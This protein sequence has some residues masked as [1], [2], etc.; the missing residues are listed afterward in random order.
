MGLDL[1]K[2]AA[3]I[4][5]LAAGLQAQGAGHRER[6][7]RAV[8]TLASADAGAINQRRSQGRVTWLVPGLPPDIAAHISPTPPPADYRALAVDGSHIDVDRHLPVRCA[9]VNISKVALQYGASP[10][11]R[12]ESQP[13]LYA[14][15]EE[16]ALVDPE[17]ARELPLEG[18][19]LGIKRSVDEVAALA[20]LAEEATD[21]TPT[22]ALVDG[23]LI[24]WGLTGQAYPEYVRRALIEDGL[25][26]AME[27]LR[28]I[29]QKRPLALAAYV[30]LPRSTEVVNALRVSVCPYEPVDC[31]RN[32]A[33]VRPGERPCDVVG[34]LLDRELFALLLAPGERSAA[35]ASTSSVVRD[36]YGGHAV[37][38]YYVNVGTEMARVEVP[39]WVADDEALLALTHSLLL[40]QCR[41][42]LGYPVAI[43]EAHEQAVIGG[44]EREMFRQM[45]EDALER[46]HLP[47]YTSE[48]ARSKRLRWV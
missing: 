17:G 22:V 11:A 30:S 3:Q 1:H 47:V 20:D 5:G 44:H 4:E 40:D 15:P 16:L 14:S 26:P 39:A 43:M 9:L 24:L 25:L 41:K 18:P 48:K 28:S 2:V 6:L 8:T 19:L 33:T 45:V 21:D 42:G 13:K 34:G 27:R 38:F 37:A 31:D 29:A 7:E 46:Q 32:C 23:S 12:L 10:H 36:Y 35:F